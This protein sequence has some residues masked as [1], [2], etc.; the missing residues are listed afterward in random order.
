MKVVS[1]TRWH[2]YATALCKITCQ[3][4]GVT[5]FTDMRIADKTGRKMHM[6]L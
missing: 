1:K 2:I 3:I 5:S 4:T 6:L